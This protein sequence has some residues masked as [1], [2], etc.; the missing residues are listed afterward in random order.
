MIYITLDSFR[1]H[2]EADE[3]AVRFGFPIPR[4]TLDRR[5]VKVKI[6]INKNISVSLALFVL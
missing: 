5:Q 4:L 3:T 1:C 6:I 2:T